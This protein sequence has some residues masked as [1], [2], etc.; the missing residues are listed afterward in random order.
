VSNNL[1]GDYDALAAFSLDAV[2]RVLAAM[3]RGKRL[4]HSLSMY[5]SD[6]PH[7]NLG[8]TAVSMLDKFGDVLS[9]TR[10]VK[11][12]AL[13]VVARSKGPIPQEVLRN[14]DPVVNLRPSSSG[15]REIQLPGV[16]LAAGIDIVGP[17]I[18]PGGADSDFLFGVAQLQLGPPTM[19]IPSNRSDR[20]EIHTPVTIR[21]IGDAHSRPISPWMQGDFITTFGV[22]HSGANIIVDLAGPSSS[23]H[24]NPTWSAVGLDAGDR[25]ALDKVLTKSLH[26]SFQPSTTQMPSKFGRMDFKG[27]AGAGVAALM[28]LNGNH[29]SSPASVSSVPLRAGDHFVLA[30]NGDAVTVPFANSV[31]SSISPRQQK[32]DTKIVI[33]YLVGTKTFHIYTTVTVLDSVVE[34]VDNPLLDFAGIPGT[35]QIVLTIPVQVRFGWE[36]KPTFVPD[37]VNFDFSIV[38]VFTLTLS[39]RHVGI[40]QLGTVAILFPDGVPDNEKDPARKQATDLFNNA[41]KNQQGN[42]QSQI[43]NALKSWIPGGTIQEYQW[44]VP[45][46]LS[47]VD[48]HRF[49]TINAPALTASGS[50][51]CMTYTGRRITASGPVFYENVSAGRRCQ[52][53]SIPLSMFRDGVDLA[54]GNRPHVVVPKPRANPEARL[55]AAAHASPWGDGGGPTTN[56]VAHFPDEQSLMHLDQLSRALEQSGRTDTV[57]A[58][59]CV[60]AP[61]QV[62]RVRVSEE[63]MYADDAAPW[64]RLL[65]VHRRP[66]TIIVN[67]LGDEVWRHEGEIGGALAEAL[68]EHLARG[69]V[70]VPALIQSPLRP[71]S[72]SPN[73]IFDCDGGDR[74]TLRKLS[75]RAVA[76]VFWRSSS[77]PSMATIGNLHR[78]FAQ[79]GMDPPLLIAINDGESGEFVRGLAAIE[80]G[81]V[82]VVPD[83]AR[84]IASAYG[85]TLWP[86]TVFLDA[87]GIVQEVRLGLI[88][89]QDLEAP[90]GSRPPESVGPE[91]R[92]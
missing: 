40:Q 56:F 27:F 5:V 66:T 72:L 28:N 51:I 85:V 36:N 14:V 78:G 4:P 8:M 10:R 11:A 34:L 2:D 7:I 1:T 50:R 71:G 25:A 45:G 43:D 87:E 92:S 65:G 33:K 83:P 16:D 63:L 67:A 23:V 70:F 58:L 88:T 80:Q 21:Y 37:P 86:T 6:E 38:A 44:S 3:H 54:A 24:F 41:W 9:D 60:L 53:T 61:D 12:G 91:G 30:V 35:G 77:A 68:R 13:A 81:E 48:K 82:M 84:Q 59:L 18:I 20:A 76:L 90:V 64:E 57:T 49:V 26:D 32:T 19:Q 29:N 46:G 39:G 31:N 75:G 47:V 73:F 52:W 17:G 74:L 62:S 22:K 79:P 15:T 89:V 42:V 69:G 55:E